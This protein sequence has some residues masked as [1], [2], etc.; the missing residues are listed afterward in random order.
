MGAYFRGLPRVPSPCQLMLG[1]QESFG[2]ASLMQQHL[3][4]QDR[5]L[6]T[7]YSMLFRQ[8]RHCHKSVLKLMGVLKAACDLTRSPTVPES[9]HSSSDMIYMID[10]V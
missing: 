4:S 3:K 2:L 1:A 5:L 7:V 6:L 10:Q 9:M 8:M